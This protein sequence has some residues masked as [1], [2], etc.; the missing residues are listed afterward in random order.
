MISPDTQTD[1]ENQTLLQVL[2]RLSDAA[3][4]AGLAVHEIRDRLDE[5]AYGLLVLILAIPC[6]V[7]GLYGLPQVVGIAIIILAFQ[8]LVG[9]KEPWLP[10]WFLQLRAKASWLKGMA[11]FAEAR[12]GWLERLSR[13]RLTFFSVGPG[14]KFAAI[15]MILA[16]LTI[17]LP[18]TNTIP[19]IALS[20]LAVGLIQRDGLFVLAGAALTS[21]W[22]FALAAVGVGFLMGADWA[23]QL[24]P[25]P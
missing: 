17:I 21:V 22:I 14:E 9:R 2:R 7:P 23:L 20:L 1:N 16:T 12:L 15:F 8:L 3:G 6:L 18:L 10:R 5:R 4:E 19:S 11:D 24:I 13:P 25:S